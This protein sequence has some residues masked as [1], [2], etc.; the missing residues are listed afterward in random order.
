[1]QPNKKFITISNNKTLIEDML[2]DLVLMPRI[3]AL[4]WAKITKQT[5]NLKIGYPGQHLASLVVGMEGAKTGARG[6]DIVDG[7]EVKSC[8]RVDQLDT[9]N[10]C[11][12]KVLRIELQCPNCKSLNIKRVDDSKWLFTIRSENDLKV[13]TQ[14]VNRVI[15]SIADYPQFSTRNFEDLRFQ[16]FEIWTQSPRNKH[17]VTLMTNYYHKIYLEHKKKNTNKTPAPKNF[18]TYSYQF[19]MCN[20]IKIFNCIV[21][22]ANTKPSITIDYYVSP[23]KDRNSLPSEAMP[24]DILNKQELAIIAEKTKIDLQ[25]LKQKSPL[26]NEELR[27]LLPLRGT[28]KISEA[29]QQYQR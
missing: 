24:I 5:P 15:L 3:K 27:R 25:E 16:I 13:L 18:W 21:K 11:S 2:M 12:E 10:E 29:K 19:Y 1:M 8:S 22:K 4:E 7:S 9:C 23:E 17:F 28:D 20:P 26:I 14:D 6:N